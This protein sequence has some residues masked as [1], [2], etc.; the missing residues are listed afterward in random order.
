MSWRVQLGNRLGE[1]RALPKVP[2]PGS[3]EAGCGLESFWPHSLPCCTGPE[4]PLPCPGPTGGVR[5]ARW[6]YIFQ[7]SQATTS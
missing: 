4:V 5:L 3:G 6:S 2:Q 1:R 7:P